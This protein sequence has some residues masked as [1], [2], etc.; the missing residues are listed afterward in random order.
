MRYLFRKLLRDIRHSA[1][2]YV[3]ITLVITIGV[4]CYVGMMS[5]SQSVGRNVDDF[6]ASQNLAD[7]WVTV[8]SAPASTIDQIRQL[9]GVAAA[10]GRVAT[11][12][13]SGAQSFVVQG[14]TPTVNIPA[15]DSGRLPTDPDDCIIDRG[16]ATANHLGAGDTLT[17]TID[18]VSH[19]LDVVGVFNSPEYLYLAK[20]VTTQPDHATYGALFVSAS[21]FAGAPDNQIVVKAQ[22][23]ADLA[24]LKADIAQ[25]TGDGVILDRT[26]LLSWSMLNQDITQYGQLGAVFPVIFFVVAAAIIFISMS[27]NVETQRNQIGNMKA[28]GIKDGMITFHFLGYSLLTCLV[29]SVLG[30][31][32]GLFGVMPGIEL[33]FT[34]YYTM[35]ALHAT[36]F[37]LNIAVAALLAFAFGIV[38]T[39]LSVR[40]PLRE[41]PAT[42]MRPKPPRS[43][44]PIL[45]ERTR[46]WPRLSFG[47]KII[48]R[49]LM[50]NKV[51]ALLSSVGIIGCVGLLL[52]SFS[53]LNSIGNVL[54]PKF[55]AMNQ[56]DVSVALASPLPPGS[57][58]PSPGADIT[59][60]APSGSLPAS[61]IGDAQVVSTQLTALDAGSTAI[62]LFDASGKRLALT[63]HA[64]IIPQLFA[65]KYGLAIGDSMTL[66]VA[67]IGGTPT[68][69]T[70]TVGAIGVQYLEQDIYASFGYLTALGV[71]VPVTTFYLTV[72]DGTA[73][74]VAAS[75]G[76]DPA[77]A[78]VITKADLASA[79]SSEMSLL[80]S[81]VWVMI[82]ASAVLALTV[83]YNISAI[84]IFER[85]RDIATL[86][87]L[88]YHQNEV[89]R[90]VFRENLIITGFGA[91]LGIPAGVGMLRLLIGAVISDTMTMPMVV[92]PLSVLY[93]VALG[94]GFTV[95]ANQLLRGKIRQID[96]VGSLKSVE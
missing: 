81:L 44:R 53:F 63:N 1:G 34:A 25:I 8:A 76:Q 51:R 41:S 21:L 74:S 35:P 83:V 47:A 17:V 69:V 40:R 73:A 96:M 16:Y 9:P 66:T 75:L 64:V 61:F 90:L 80:N 85:R 19:A 79:W 65:Q 20:D 3:A 86:K 10:D 84:N 87:V 93:A 62:A 89:N 67:P 30:V 54:G 58:F 18:G 39:V 48:W 24:Q 91:V 4:A 12:G 49:N 57:G 26:Q 42:A 92:S 82:A 45:L 33:I 28:L 29:G 68:P 22:P 78:Q 95:L 32:A 60:A 23:G 43:M 55:D 59:A 15:M 72:R 38:A 5:V 50:L 94:M 36:G 14:L 31:F 7:L 71:Q 2:Q 52:A 6:Y 88:G 70:V 11:T 27:K 37:A 77:F 46:W 56:Y 13:T